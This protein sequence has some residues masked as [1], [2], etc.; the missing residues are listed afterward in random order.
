M[1]DLTSELN[2]ALAE[3]DD[4]NADYLVV[5]LRSSLQILDGL[6][7]QA[8][9]H[10]HNG[11]HQGGAL[12]FQDLTVGE[13]LIVNG[14]S[15][16]KQTV[17]AQGA[18]NAQGVLNVTGLA[19]F[20]G[21]ITTGGGALTVGNTQVNGT[22]GVTGL[23]TFSGDVNARNMTFG[24]G[25]QSILTSRSGPLYLRPA[26]GAPVVMDTGTQLTLGI[27]L[28]SS[29]TIAG[30]TLY[31]G[32]SPVWTAASAPVAVGPSANTLAM[33]DGSGNVQANSV[34]MPSGVQAAKPAYVC[35]QTGDG[36]MRWWP[37]SA[38][39]PPA[40]RSY[41]FTMTIPIHNGNFQA[42]S[43][44]GAGAAGIVV[45]NGSSLTAVRPGYYSIY[46][47]GG[48]YNN[49]GI[50]IFTE[51]VERAAGGTGTPNAPDFL[52]DIGASWV[53]FI[54]AGGLISFQG[55]SQQATWSGN[56]I[57]TFIPETTY[58]A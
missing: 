29:S 5:S 2:L 25:T 54:N 52:S 24:D 36:Y 58:N 48:G 44:A 56:A 31:S 20:S 51:G 30:S 14:T 23:T 47:E 55:R 50:K 53:G 32:G 45:N 9:G 15:L 35:G 21:G 6:F 28:S 13:D 40:L 46:A 7:N 26:A 8:T 1:S 10:T 42:C 4:D 34:Y 39:G 18:L 38:I 17:T 16:L 12:L 27:P 49:V 22:L 43:I 11:A 3:D 33:R 19:T 41:A 37:A 57:V